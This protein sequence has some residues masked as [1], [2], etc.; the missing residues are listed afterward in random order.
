MKSALLPE[1]GLIVFIDLQVAQKS[2]VLQNELHLLYLLT[3]VSIPEIKVNWKKYYEII[4]RLS[5]IEKT[6]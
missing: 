2:L 3:P 4:R 1:E 6:I 5:P